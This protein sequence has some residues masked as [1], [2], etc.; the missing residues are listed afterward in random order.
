MNILLDHKEIKRFSN[1]KNKINILGCSEV[2]EVQENILLLKTKE[3]SFLKEQVGTWSGKPVVKFNIL[4]E[5]TLHKDVSFVIEQNA[6]TALNFDT[7]GISKKPVIASI[8][9]ESKVSNDL[10][11]Q[12]VTEHAKQVIASLFCAYLPFLK[13]IPAF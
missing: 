12:L 10:T 4:V 11:P 3:N 9:T 8:L 1:T 2:T 5:N 6:E 13:S 7:L